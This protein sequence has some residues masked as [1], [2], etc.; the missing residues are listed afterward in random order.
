MKDSGCDTIFYG[1]ES[2]D[3]RILKSMNKGITVS[4][5]ERVLS[6]TKKV[7]IAALGAFIFGDPEETEETVQNTLQWA[8]V[9]SDLLDLSW[10][11]PIILYP[12]SQLYHD[13]VMDR[14]VDP[15]S[16]IRNKCPHVNVSKLSD[17]FFSHLINEVFPAVSAR[18]Y[19]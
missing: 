3:D 7:G 13:A 5:I 10:F 2:A 4:M 18:L 19:T 1:I 15:V 9:N 8:N 11:Q 12:G 6:L 17:E 16:H 14:K